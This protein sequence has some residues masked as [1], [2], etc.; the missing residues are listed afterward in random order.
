MVFT[1]TGKQKFWGW[2]K[3]IWKIL[4]WK[5]NFFLKTKSK[6]LKNSILATFLSNS[7]FQH[8]MSIWNNFSFHLMYILSILIKNHGLSRIFLSWRLIIWLGQMR[9]LWCPILKIFWTNI[10]FSKLS[11]VWWTLM[12]N[13]KFVIWSYWF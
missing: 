12:K 4:R 11:H 5:K 7:T 3:K 13:D 9:L 1:T 8:Q 2:L 6:I 10:L